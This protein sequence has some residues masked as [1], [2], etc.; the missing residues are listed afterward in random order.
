MMNELYFNNYGVLVVDVPKQIMVEVRKEADLIQSDFSKASPYNEGLAGNINHEYDAIQLKPVLNELLLHLSD[1]YETSFNYL[2]KIRVLTK[3]VPLE[4]SSLWFNFQKK[5]EYN[6]LH[7]HS[8]VYS[9]VM[10][11]KIPYIRQKELEYASKTPVN[12]NRNGCFTF[13]YTSTLG[14]LEEYCVELDTSFENKLVFFPAT[15]HHV[16]YPFFTSDEYRIS[17]AGNVLLSGA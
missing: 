12:V 7:S 11:V 2:N 3:N 14:T 8:G 1:Q 4:V 16:V 15:M 9:F 17:L 6:P 5:G 10:W 13:I